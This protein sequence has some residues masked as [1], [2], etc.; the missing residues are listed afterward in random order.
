LQNLLFLTTFALEWGHGIA[1]SKGYLGLRTCSKTRFF[2]Y[3]F[4]PA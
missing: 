3:L 1:P 4:F 2:G